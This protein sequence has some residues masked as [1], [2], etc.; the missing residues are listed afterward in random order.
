MLMSSQATSEHQSDSVT[1]TILERIAA[2]T[3]QEPQELSPMYEVIDPD[4]FAHLCGSGQYD[5][6]VELSFQYEGFTITVNG[7]GAIEITEA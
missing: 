6:S 2:R 3:G 5:E 4:I 1:F 7:R